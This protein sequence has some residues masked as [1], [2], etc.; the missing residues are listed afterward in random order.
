MQQ[1]IKKWL[2]LLSHHDNT[3]LLEHYMNSEE[4]ENAVQLAHLFQKGMNEQGE[5][6]PCQQLA[7]DVIDTKGL[8][9]ALIAQIKTSDALSFFTP[10]LQLSHNFKKTNPRLRNVLHYTFAGHPSALDSVPAFNYLRSMMLFESNGVLRTALCQRD[11]ENLTPI[12]AYLFTHQNFAPLPAQEFS[13]LLA[14]IEIETTQQAIVPANYQVKLQYLVASCKSQD[15]IMNTEL[16]RI[17]LIAIYFTK[18]VNIIVNELNS[19]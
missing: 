15:Q 11:H 18:S 7:T 13:A 10:A 9:V 2:N 12:E 19:A 1:H 16:Q 8:P 14:L 4:S 6:E 17:I 5:F 3:A